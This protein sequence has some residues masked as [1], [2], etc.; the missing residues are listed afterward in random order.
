MNCGCTKHIG[1]FTPNDT[2]NFGITAPYSGEY[3]FEI[4][5]NTGFS[6]ILQTFIFGEPI[7]IPFTFNENSNTIIKIKTDLINTLNGFYYITTPDGA[8]SFE[9]SGIIPSC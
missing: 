7:Q 9:F 8:C 2:I 4:F 6:T 1:C 3:T 5:S